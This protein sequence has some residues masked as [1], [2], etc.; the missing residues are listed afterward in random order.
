MSIL[1][2]QNDYLLLHPNYEYLS[3]AVLCAFFAVL[4]GLMIFKRRGTQSFT[5]RTAE[6][7]TY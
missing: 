3:F 2:T 7:I 6:F 4:C 5:Q 1:K